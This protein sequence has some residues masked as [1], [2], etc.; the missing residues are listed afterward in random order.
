MLSD[1]ERG[2]IS[3]EIERYPT[4]RALSVEALKIVQKE[5]GWVSDEA[6]ADVAEILQMSTAELDGIATFYNQIHRR[7]VG[8]HVVQ[9]CDGV[10]CWVLGYDRLH[11][12]LAERLGTGLGGTSA[13]GRFTFL[14]TPC[15]GACDLAP[16]LMVDDDLYGNVDV[17]DLDAILERYPGPE[18]E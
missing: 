11:Q 9:V 2:R 14:P 10:S 3:E 17:A 16:A 1:A 13:D 8:R 5:R 12:A 7:P 15:L 18:E 6:L 4:R